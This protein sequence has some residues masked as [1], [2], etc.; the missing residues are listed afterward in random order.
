ML[1]DGCVIEVGYISVD[2]SMFFVDFEG[3]FDGL[4]VVMIF[5]MFNNDII[6]VDSDGFNIIVDGFDLFLQ[7][8]EGQDGIYVLENVGW[9]VI[10]SGG[11]GDFGMV[12][13]VDGVDEV[14]DMI[15]FGFMINDVVVIVKIQIMNGMDIVYVVINGQIDDNVGVYVNEE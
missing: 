3:D 9:I 13:M 15:G 14:I 6:I 1:F 12:L 7:E 11:F 5:V 4:F 8:E 10:E 2:D